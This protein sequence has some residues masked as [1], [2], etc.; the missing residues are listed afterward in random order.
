MGQYQTNVLQDLRDKEGERK[1]V[2]SIGGIRIKSHR[3]QDHLAN[4]ELLAGEYNMNESGK[5]SMHLGPM[6][7][8]VEVVGEKHSKKS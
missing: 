7:R 1:V 4:I 3:V 8:G 5:R 6:D 2:T